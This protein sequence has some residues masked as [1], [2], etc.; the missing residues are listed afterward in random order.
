MIVEFDIVAD[1]VSDPHPTT[2]KVKTIK[3]NIVFK[4]SFI[5]ENTTYA[6]YLN[7][8]GKISKSYCNLI[9]GGQYYKAKH[10]YEYVA[11]KLKPIIVKGFLSH[12]KGNTKN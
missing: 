6:H 9:S 4:Q 3:R 5:S 8:D 11:D 7:K 2:G 12:A 1:I 10:S